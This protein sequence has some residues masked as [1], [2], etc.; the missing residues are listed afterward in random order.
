M[1]IQKE[2]RAGGD[3][4]GA[5]ALLED[6][7]VLPAERGLAAPLTGSV[8]AAAAASDGVPDPADAPASPHPS[9]TAAVDRTRVSPTIHLKLFMRLLPE[10]LSDVSERAIAIIPEPDRF[11]MSY[12]LSVCTDA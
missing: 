10:F 6:D 11:K 3:G 9:K 7:W 4:V 8:L 12:L 2:A 5:A 1:G